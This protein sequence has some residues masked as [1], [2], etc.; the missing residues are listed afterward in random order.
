MNKKFQINKILIPYDFSETA[1]L[2]L[3]H[4]V[5]MAKLHKA[6]IILLHVIE[7]YSFTSAI[8]N[9][10]SKSQVEF[11]SKIESSA[12][13]K[14]EALANKLHHNSGMTVLYRTVM[15]KIYKTIVKMAEEMNIDI[16]IMGT[17]GVSGF[18]E[19]LIGSN[20]YKVVMASPCPVISVQTH[21]TKIGFKNIVLPID[22]SNTSRQKVKHC[23]ELAK[24]YNSK[25]HIA[26]LANMTDTDIL[27]RFDVKIHQVKEYLD[28]HE[29]PYTLEMFKG[30]N[31]ASIVMDFA[32][33]LNADL[34]IMMTDQENSGLFMGNFAQQII[35]HSKIPVMSVRPE[36]GDPDKISLGY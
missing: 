35:N 4:A 27:R 29:I 9:A 30:D 8:S 22:N 12:N 10:F 3:E 32:T 1:D 33:K 16:I 15:G 7:S 20:T 14:L 34:I 28:E 25:V 31:S 18:Q 5:F 23:V 26:G 13:E 17:H 6:E 21:A 19:F 36:E 24:H 2:A 11:E